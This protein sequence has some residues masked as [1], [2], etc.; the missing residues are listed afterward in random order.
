MEKAPKL[1]EPSLSEQ[2]ST[3]PSHAPDLDEQLLKKHYQQPKLALLGTVRTI[4][5][6]DGSVC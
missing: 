6:S 3:V 1:T 4:T 2:T 5:A